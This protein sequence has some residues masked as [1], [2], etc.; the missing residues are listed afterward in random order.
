MLSPGVLRV[1]NTTGLAAIHLALMLSIKRRLTL[2]ADSLSVASEPLALLLAYWMLDML[3]GVQAFT[4]AVLL[5]VGHCRLEPL[6][7]P[8]LLA[9]PI[10]IRNFPRHLDTLILDVL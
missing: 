2:R 9:P 1:L 3:T 7:L 5:P 4:R 8:T 6:P 10:N